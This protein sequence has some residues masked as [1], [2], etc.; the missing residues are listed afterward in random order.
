VRLPVAGFSAQ[1]FS[2]L[3]YPFLTGTVGFGTGMRVV[4]PLCGWVLEALLGAVEGLVD[5]PALEPGSG[6][7]LDPGLA[8]VVT[9]GAVLLLPGPDPALGLEP[10]ELH[11]ARPRTAAQRE[12]V[13]ARLEVNRTIH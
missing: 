1:Y 13:S 3:A 8:D 5:V 4:V 10:L 7:V 6:E 9:P 2:L 11:P 12:T